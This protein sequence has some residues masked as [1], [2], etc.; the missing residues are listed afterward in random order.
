MKVIK[1]IIP[2]IICL[3]IMMAPSMMRAD[4][5][6][7][8]SPLSVVV[9]QK[10]KFGGDLR[11]RFDTQRRDE[12]PGKDDMDRRQWRFRLRFGLTLEPIDNVEAGFRLAS[13]SGFQN[14]TNQSYDS[15]ARG[16]DIFIDR[17]Y[18]SWKP[19]DPL[20]LVGGKF[21]NPF[22]TSTL[23]WDSDVNPEGLSFQ[24]SHDLDK[25]EIFGNATHFFVE[26][27]D[28]K[29]ESNRDP[30]MGGY[31]GGVVVKPTKDIRVQFGATYYDFRNLDL[32]DSSGLDDDTKF[33]GYN[34]ASDQQMVFDADGHLLNKFKCF[35]L[36]AK[37]KANNLLPVPL[38]VF[39]YYVKNTDADIN[40]LQERGVALD[41]SDPS[42]LSAYGDDNRDM[43][44][45]FGVEI[46]KKKQKNDFFL[47]YYYQLI[48][49]YAFPAVFVDSDFNGGGTNNKGHRIEAKYYL[50][51]AVVLQGD[52]LITKRENE[53]KDGKQDENR[54]R[55]DLIINF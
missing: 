39:G 22:F 50:A 49:D 8:D 16:K 28:L 14:T 44:Y 35:E 25:F 47:Q 19:V 32:Y 29:E 33:V 30:V 43:G 20:K 45:Q 48:E 24:L 11:L 38:G 12:G 10:T 34:Q 4:G 5:G 46:G 26:E 7:E 23:V 31:Q 17:V 9:K 37:V 21:E 42:D 15:H 18:A 3:G 13:G 41:A 40:E 55:L 52:L 53:A 2:L 36:G 6:E 27:L 1:S 54:A 51:D